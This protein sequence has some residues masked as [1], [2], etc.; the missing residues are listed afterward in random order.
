MPSWSI[1]P[2]TS[3]QALPRHWRTDES[4]GVR[5]PRLRLEPARQVSTEERIAQHQ[6]SILAEGAFLA[7]PDAAHVDED[8][9]VFH[10]RH[11]RD[12]ASAPYHACRIAVQMHPD[13][14]VVQ[15][16]AGRK[17][18]QQETVI[19]AVGVRLCL[20]DAVAGG[21]VERHHC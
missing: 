4:A 21:A 8:E 9:T 20:P 10:E 11:P 16:P 3:S 19:A 12:L 2:S 7:V 14:C 6:Y 17:R 15:R 18:R 13:P 5:A 1:I